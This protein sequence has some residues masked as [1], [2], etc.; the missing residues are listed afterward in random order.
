MVVRT[1]NGFASTMDL[2]RDIDE[3][4]YLEANPEVRRVQA[5]LSLM[6]QM[7]FEEA[8]KFL[9]GED[10]LGNG[11]KLDPNVTYETGGTTAMHMAALNDDAEG[12]RLLLRYGADKEVKDDDGQMALDMAGMVDAKTVIALLL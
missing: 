1:E 11:R 12:V 3:H 7:E 5:F 2:G 10:E 4:A 8:E 9:K 6:S